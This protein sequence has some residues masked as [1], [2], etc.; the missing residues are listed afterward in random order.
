MKRTTF[1]QG[2]VM[3]TLAFAAATFLPQAQSGMTDEQYLSY[4][5]SIPKTERDDIVAMIANTPENFADAFD[6][7]ARLIHPRGRGIPEAIANAA[8]RIRTRRTDINKESLYQQLLAVRNDIQR[9]AGDATVSL[10]Q[11]ITHVIDA[12]VKN[13]TYS[14]GE[15]EENAQGEDKILPHVHMTLNKS[16][17]LLYGPR[18]RHRRLFKIL[19][20][21]ISDEIG[22]D[23]NTKDGFD[24]KETVYDKLDLARTKLNDKTKQ[25]K[26][27]ITQALAELDKMTLGDCEQYK[28]RVDA[29]STTK[30]LQAAINAVNGQPAKNSYGLLGNLKKTA[31][32]NGE[33]LA[34]HDI[35]GRLK[36]GIAHLNTLLN[37]RV[38]EWPYPHPPSIGEITQ[39]VIAKTPTTLSPND[40]ADTGEGAGETEGG[41]G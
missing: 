14:V 26:P 41:G 17:D 38:S 11:S 18:E 37:A 16:K 40:P 20:R 4:W 39:E 7:Y 21:I 5:A 1:Y 34:E 6:Y 28:A 29:R 10:S 12:L 13:S 24:S 33:P 19:T 3:G 25:P 35:Y 2:M 31:T 8:N 23:G 22:T 36:K 15:S 9:P 30:T 27:T 32:A